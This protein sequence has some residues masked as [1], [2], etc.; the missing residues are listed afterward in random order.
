MQRACY[1]FQVHLILTQTPHDLDDLRQALLDELAEIT[2]NK[3]GFVINH[4]Q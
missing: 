4:F 2:N 1:N 3:V